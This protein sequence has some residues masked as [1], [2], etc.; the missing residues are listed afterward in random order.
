MVCRMAIRKMWKCLWMGDSDHLLPEDFEG[1]LLDVLNMLAK[2]QRDLVRKATGGDHGDGR[3]KNLASVKIEEFFGEKGTSAYSYRQWKKS[4]EVT[5]RSHE[6]NDQKLAMIMYTQLKGM[7]KKRVEILELTDLERPDVLQIIWEILDRS[8]EQL[9]HERVDDAY[10]AWDSLHRRPGQ[11]M[12]DYITRVRRVKLEMESMDSASK[13]SDQ[14]LASK[15]LRGAGLSHEKRAQALIN[16]GGVYDPTRLE[17][18]LRVT[19]PK[20]G[21]Q[22]RKQGHRLTSRRVRQV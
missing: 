4:V 17:T 1:W 14:A 16:C 18:V 2:T 22:E 20:I 21:D 15:M 8:Y 11:S 5:R 9:Q 13:I 10:H 12:E 19:F 3:S 7:A 6:L